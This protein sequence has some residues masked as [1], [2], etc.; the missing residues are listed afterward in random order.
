MALVLVIEDGS[1]ADPDANSYAT[2]AEFDDHFTCIGV[3]ISGLTSDQK[4]AGLIG[5]ATQVMEFCYEYKGSITHTESPTQPLLWPRTGLCD[6][7]GL[8]IDGSSIPD[9]IKTAQIEL[10]RQFAIQSNYIY[11]DEATNTGAVK[12]E[13]LDV[14]EQQFYG[15][16]TEILNTVVQNANQW[17]R[18]ILAPYLA[19]GNNPFQI[20]NKAVV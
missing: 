10:A 4:I 1:G 5:A 14:L 18:K 7:R 17:V 8:E 11:S 13:K 15:P 3:D 20:N 9:D 19:S 2:E 16:G 6:R 12:K